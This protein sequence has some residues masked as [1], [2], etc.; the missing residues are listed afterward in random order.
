MYSLLVF[1]LMTVEL[2]MDIALERR[3]KTAI[4]ILSGIYLC[5]NTNDQLLMYKV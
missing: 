2:L 5:G 1:E 3:A 4:N